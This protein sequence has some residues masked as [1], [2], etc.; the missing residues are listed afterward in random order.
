MPFRIIKPSAAPRRALEPGRGESLRFIDTGIGV[1][2]GHQ[3]RIFDRFYRVS[4]D[5]GEVGAGLGLAIVRAICHAHG[6][7][8]SLRSSP[9]SGS[10]FRVERYCRPFGAQTML[11]LGTKK[12]AFR[13]ARIQ[14]KF[15]A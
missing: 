11:A 5:R 15:I 10:C 14:K 12:R 1:E 4:T 2:P 6:G 3:E 13:V 9:K 8:I 7:T